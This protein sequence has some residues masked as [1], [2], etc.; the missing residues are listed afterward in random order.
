MKKTN[1]QTHNIEKIITN[2]IIWEDPAS[3]PVCKDEG[4]RATEHQEAPGPV[5]ET[6]DPVSIF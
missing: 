6:A 1:L 3:H 4:Q 2:T 5:S